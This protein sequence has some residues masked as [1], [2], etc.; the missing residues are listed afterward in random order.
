ME[1]LNDAG[2]WAAIGAFIIALVGAC[3][4]IFEYIRY[5]WNFRKKRIA[6]EAYLKNEKEKAQGS[7]LFGQKSL[8]NI[9]RHVGLTENEVLKISFSSDKITRKLSKEKE[10][11]FADRLL[12]EYVGEND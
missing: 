11:V 6:L 7:S 5:K 8:L 10:D 12:F 9:I 4:G 1:N 3:V 2:N